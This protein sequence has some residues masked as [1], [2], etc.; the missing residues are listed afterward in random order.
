[1]VCLILLLAGISPV[2]ALFVFL[3]RTAVLRAVLESHVM[4]GITIFVPFTGDE[5]SLERDLG[6]S[7]FLTATQSTQA[8]PSLL[9]SE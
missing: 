5:Q 1:M 2:R 6:K 3:V 4:G 9:S 7:V 8:K